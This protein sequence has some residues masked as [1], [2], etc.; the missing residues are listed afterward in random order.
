MASFWYLY[1]RLEK[2]LASL[3]SQVLIPFITRQYSVKSYQLVLVNF[4]EF[5]KVNKALNIEN[6]EHFSHL[7][8]EFL[9]LTL[10]R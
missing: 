8:L 1:L 10:S 5:S 2:L 6:F 7:V 3:N 9:F 4:P